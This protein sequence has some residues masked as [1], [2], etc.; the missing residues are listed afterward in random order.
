MPADGVHDIS[1]SQVTPGGGKGAL[2]IWRA[3]PNQ[4]VKGRSSISRSRPAGQLALSGV[5]MRQHLSF[6]D[7][8]KASG[9]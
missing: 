8:G 4:P 7:V 5:Y 3:L 2:G 1:L 6:I 9:G